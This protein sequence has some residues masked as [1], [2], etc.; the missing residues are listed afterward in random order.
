MICDIIVSKFVCGIFLIF[1]Q[2][3]FINNYGEEQFFGTKKLAKVKYLETHLFFKN[4]RTL[5][6]KSY[7]YK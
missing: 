4:F 2:S 6:C 5:F 1:C 7:L 3:S